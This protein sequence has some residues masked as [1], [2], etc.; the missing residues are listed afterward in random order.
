M[1]ALPCQGVN[2]MEKSVSLRGHE[3]TFS[4]WDIGGH[5]DFESMLPLVCNDAA[6]M[7]LLFDLSK[8]ET[9]D[10]IRVWHQKARERNKCAMPLL[11]G[12]K[13]DLMLEAPVEEQQHVLWMSHQFAKAIN[14][15]LIFCAPSVPINVTNVFKMILINLF[16]LE[17]SVAQLTRLGQPVIL[18]AD[19]EI[20][21]TP[22][23]H[24]LP[25]RLA[26]ENGENDG[27][28]LASVSG[29]VPASHGQRRVSGGGGGGVN[30]WGNTTASS[31]LSMGV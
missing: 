29:M 3:V 20:D 30:T 10:S 26:H 11:V 28:G 18:Y 5:K 14:S 17:R 6:A 4:I 13:F 25:P 2:F 24:V 15:P 23:Q 22:A 27:S 21:R 1:H 16:H 9:L 31:G 7:L 19:G 8:P 12:C